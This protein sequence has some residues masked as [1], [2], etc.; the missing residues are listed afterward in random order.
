M[1]LDERAQTLIDAMADQGARPFEL[2]TPQECREVVDT[3]T[4]LQA[5][6]EEVAQVLDSTYQGPAGDQSL[7]IYIPDAVGPLPIVVYFHGGGF[8]G[9]GL[10]VVDEPARALANDVGT[11]VV[12]VSYRLAPENK[13]PAATD[14]TFAAL[15][16]VA[17][18]ATEFGGD[19]ERI[20]VM[21][22]SA[23]GNLAAVAAQRARDEGGPHLAAQVLIYPVVDSTANLPSRTEFGDGYVITASAL[24]WFWEQYLPSLAAAES[25]LATP[26]RAQSLADLPPALV[27]STECEVSRDE[28]EAYARQ[29]AQAGVETE[30]VR[31][32]GLMHGAYWMSGAVPRSREI[33]DAIVRFLSKQFAS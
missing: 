14:D 10:A 16:W 18:H 1:P 7:R 15:K 3:F 17:A 11:I 24:D 33:H 21:G 25:P 20:A 30:A 27:L 9:G 13:F 5:P 22:D 31:L 23:G 4:G 26:S 8:V 28:A 29:L 2:M 6:P 32:D 19:P 12:T